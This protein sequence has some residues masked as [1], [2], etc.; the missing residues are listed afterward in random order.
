MAAQAVAASPVTDVLVIG[1]GGA[2][3]RAALAARAAGCAV[4]VLHTH[5]GASPFILAFNALTAGADSGD[6]AERYGADMVRGGAGLN[7]RRL[8]SSLVHGTGAVVSELAE[9]G[10]PFARTE[11]DYTLRHLGGSSC[12]RSVYVREGTGKAA[13]RVMAARAREHGVELVAGVRVLSLLRHGGRVVGALAVRLRDGALFTVQ[14]GAVVLAAGGAGRIYAGSTYPTDVNGSGYALAYAA[15]ATL[16]DMEFVQFEPTVVAPPLACH[17]MEMPTAML[18]DGAMLLNNQGEQFMLRYNPGHG[19]KGVEKAFLACCIQREVDEGRGFPGGT[20]LFDARV[21]PPQVLEG[22]PNHVRRLRAAA[23]D[24]AREAVPVRPAAH[25]HM[26]G[27]HIEPGGGTGVPG[28]FAAGEVT[29]GVHGA[30]RL[31]GNSGSDVLVNGGLAGRSAAAFASGGQPGTV[32]I[33]VL[34]AE[35]FAAMPTGEILLAKQVKERVS[36]ILA[37]GAGLIR[38]EALLQ[39]GRTELAEVGA[40]L[41]TTSASTQLNGGDARTVDIPAVVEHL[42][43]QQH[44]LVAE[45]I[46]ASALARTESRGAH[47]RTDCP[48]RDDLHWTC[49]LAIRRTEGGAMAISSHPVT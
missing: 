23:L 18:G 8:V 29:G 22:Y 13:L 2:G 38:S 4:T 5:S 37:H 19:E 27:V 35:A 33:A 44:L 10:V 11:A 25:S 48:E 7:D 15:G 46:L 31:A 26:G 40:L 17:G 28:L 24:P 1:A 47:R 39:A 30:S 9:W 49:H 3:L 32:P 14:A 21:L 45:M 36:N 16:V 6:S 34:A 12:P 43:A 41:A 20:V 42:E